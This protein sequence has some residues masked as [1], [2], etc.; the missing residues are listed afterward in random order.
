M[1]ILGQILLFLLQIPSHN[2]CDE[3]YLQ[4]LLDSSDLVVIAEVAK[5]EKATGA[6]SGYVLIS[7][8]VQYEVKEVLKGKNGDAVLR[9]SHLIVKNSPSTDGEKAQLS[10][11]IFAEGNQLILFISRIHSAKG[12][13]SYMVR[14]TYCGVELTRADRVKLIRQLLSKK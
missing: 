14:D 5:V 6:W 7:Q 10:P 4:K 12:A 8:E 13:T 11:K 2:G 9:V 1:N 3:K